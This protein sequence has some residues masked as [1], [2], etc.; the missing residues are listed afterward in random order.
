MPNGFGMGR[1]EGPF[2]DYLKP[3]FDP[4]PVQPTGM[5]GN[6][7]AISTFATEFLKGASRA[8]AQKFQESE[9][10]R[11]RNIQALQSLASFAQNS[12]MAPAALQQF[13]QGIMQRLV[14]EVAQADNGE[15]GK[16]QG[17]NPLFGFVKNI[18]GNL[19]GPTGGKPKPID[20]QY[21]GEMFTQIAGAPKL[22][23]VEKEV[24]QKM[25]DAFTRIKT[26]KGYVTPE[27]FM[28]DQEAMTAYNA[29][30]SNGIDV[31]KHLN[32]MFRGMLSPDQA[33]VRE[34]DKAY[35]AFNGG[36]NPQ[37][38]QPQFAGTP[39]QPLPVRSASAPAEPPANGGY[40][41]LVNPN[42][43][44]LP[45]GMQNQV[46]G[47][48]EKATRMPPAYSDIGGEPPAP[49]AQQQ[50]SAPAQPPVQQFAQASGQAQMPSMFGEVVQFTPGVRR[51]MARNGVK[52]TIE[53]L[54]A[55]P[56]KFVKTVNY[57]V[58]PDGKILAVEESTGRRIDGDVARQQGYQNIGGNLPVSQM[59]VVPE[60]IEAAKRAAMARLNTSAVL[61]PEDRKEIA[62]GIETVIPGI[63][64]DSD[65]DK[66]GTF[67]ERTIAD[68]ERAADRKE[69]EAQRRADRQE[70]LALTQGIAKQGLAAKYTTAI[71]STI[72]LKNYD[73]VQQY[74]NLI[75][76]AAEQAKRGD[77]KAKGIAHLSIIRGMAKITDPPSTVREGEQRTYEDAQGFVNKWKA[78]VEGGWMNGAILDDS[79]IQQF[80][81]H[82][83]A[84]QGIARKNAADAIGP[85]LRQA[86][87]QGVPYQ[88]ILRESMWDIGDEVFRGKTGGAP[89]ATPAANPTWTP[90]KA[91]PKGF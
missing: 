88:E 33:Q 29:G 67:V 4:P 55:G 35:L 58:Q 17:G 76:Q 59:G 41:G 16:D 90:G 86:H 12:G 61:T 79:A 22:A 21:L 1:R 10:V 7:E 24:G 44:Q 18:A 27:D 68:R 83:K 40:M 66:I 82:A 48:M 8:R 26:A 43:P 78:K 30:R 13:N 15:K 5:G 65:I 52:P 64:T 75:E 80:V 39:Q 73:T 46:P 57:G 81:A 63:S 56:G 71:E 72:P 70:R 23:D 3:R 20:E 53:Y 54:F 2:D 45:G 25:S 91:K 14:A 47:Y 11:S 69:A 31:D 51:A 42:V 50:P 32:V 37:Q 34:D 9:Q 49:P 74:V 77:N 60:R 38:G 87:G 19:L 84:I 62:A 28:A 85:R 6:L 36:G 89:K